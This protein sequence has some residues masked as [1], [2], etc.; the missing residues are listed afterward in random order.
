VTD[1][2]FDDPRLAAVYDDLD[3]DRSDL[4]LYL[5]L[6]EELGASSV[7]DVGCG[8]GT[9]ACRLAQQGKD[10]TAV[11]PAAASLEIAR[12]KPHAHRVNWVFGDAT[13]L[14]PLRVDLAVMTGNVAH[15]FLRDDDWAAT[16]RAVLGALRPH[17]VFVFE[18]RDPAK[19]AWLEWT[20]DKSSRRIETRRAGPVE[21]WVEITAVDLP[22]VSFRT[23]VVFE[24]DG[25]VETSDSTLRFRS[26]PEIA[27]SL[28]EAGF[29][30]EDV[31][32]APDRPGR[33]LV[34]IARRD[35]ARS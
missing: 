8:T 19:R 21:S 23:T 6:V 26:R 9:L 22:L 13:M 31:R 33:E 5:A 30:V 12:A 35:D 11:D 27:S 28:M 32:D 15:V 29:A 14:P 34:F 1:R 18:V 4:D 24:A 3:G 16:L 25:S 17:G 20:R 10:V 7:L 2:L